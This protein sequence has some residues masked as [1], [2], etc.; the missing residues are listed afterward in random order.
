LR[1]ALVLCVVVAALAG[2]GSGAGGRTQAAAPPPQTAT[3][4]PPPTATT[5]ST[6]ATVPQ[7]LPPAIVD[8]KTPVADKP[9]L[10]LV[11]DSL[12]VGMAYVLPADLPGWTVSVDGRGGRIAGL[13]M[14]RWRAQSTPYT[15][16]AF[17]L[18][19]ADD[20]ADPQILES[21]VRESVERQFS[22]CAI[23]ATIHAP[24]RNGV[25]FDAANALLYRL[26][27]E[28]PGRLFVVPWDETMDRRPELD[29][30]DGIHP[31]P[32]GF[33][34]RARLYADAARRC[35]QE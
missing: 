13:G 6:Q 8:M 2:C 9:S 29:S 14:D 33:R 11:G 20:P 19:S 34:V 3:T 18:F 17:S 1:R 28:Y 26:Q 24:P 23:W 27:R 15:V 7:P 32:A 12:A 25:T 4:P 5:P 31:N 16:S 35:L 22:R 21:I 10:L 30:G